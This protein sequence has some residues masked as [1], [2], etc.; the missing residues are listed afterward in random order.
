MEKKIILVNK[1][2]KALETLLQLNFD[3]PR[4]AQKILEHLW[5]IESVDSLA[6]LGHFYSIM[7]LFHV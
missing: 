4:P 3:I 7:K 1:E 5:Y 6:F 2:I